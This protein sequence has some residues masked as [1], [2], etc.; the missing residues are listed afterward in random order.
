MIPLLLFFL[1]FVVDSQNLLPR[2]CTDPSTG[3]ALCSPESGMTA[4]AD[5][6]AFFNLTAGDPPVMVSSRTCKCSS[7]LASSE[8]ASRSRCPRVTDTSQL[9]G[10]TF[11]FSTAHNKALF[12]ENPWQYAPAYGGF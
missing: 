6:V 2:N 11:R 1:R 3:D 10:F 5:V 9:S 7:S 4:C 12:D 8:A